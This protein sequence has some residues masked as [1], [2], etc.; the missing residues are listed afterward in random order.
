MKHIKAEKCTL[1]MRNTNVILARFHKHMLIYS[2]KWCLP[3]RDFEALC[4]TC[5]RTTKSLEQH[6]FIFFGVID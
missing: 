6:Q 2:I 1:R 4:I 3:R 5:N